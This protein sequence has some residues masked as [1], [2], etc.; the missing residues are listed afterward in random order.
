MKPVQTSMNLILWRHAE[1]EDAVGGMPDACRCLTGRG[2]EQARTMG[3]WLKEHIPANVR[4]LVSPT[5][6]TQLTAQALGLPFVIEP[7]IGIGAYPSELLAAADW[8]NHH[9][10]VLVVGHQPTLGR[11]AALLGSGQ[12]A[13][14]KVKKGGLWWFGQSAAASNSLG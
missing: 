1:A 12:E 10:T 2:Q 5:Q 9:G 4:V 14:W 8:P 3:L 11:V 13:D 6:R 7:L